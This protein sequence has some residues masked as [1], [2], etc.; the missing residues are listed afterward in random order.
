MTRARISEAGMS[1]IE[2]L[3][4]LAILAIA[5]A[6]LVSLQ[7][8]ATRT[9]ARDERL[10]DDLRVQRNALAMLRD[11]NMLAMPEGEIALGEGAVAR[12]RARAL[13]PPVRTLPADAG[14]DVFDV[15]VMEVEVTIERPDARPRGNYAARPAQTF[16]FEQLGWRAA[17]AAQVQS[18]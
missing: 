2:A 18:P 4:A 16:T 6:P 13:S 1:V 9:Q 17:S 10:L 5:I 15:A 7:A 11:A 8:Q 14:S 3:A 12:W